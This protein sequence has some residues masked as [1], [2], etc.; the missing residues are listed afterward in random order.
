MLLLRAE[1]G[2]V[3]PKTI[4]GEVVRNHDVGT[5]ML[6]TPLYGTS[7][8]RRPLLMS[9]AFIH[10]EDEIML[11]VVTCHQIQRLRARDSDTG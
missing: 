9:G 4:T 5:R 1:A 10:T 3:R 2:V 7:R 8:G 6:C 11:V